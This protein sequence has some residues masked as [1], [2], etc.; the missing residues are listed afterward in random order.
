[1]TVVFLFQ[2]S[3][4]I[5]A[6]RSALFNRTCCLD[7]LVLTAYKHMLKRKCLHVLLDWAISLHDLL[8]RGCFA[9]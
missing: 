2:S 8:N 6:C 5:K 9:L 7:F 3:V 4:P 1:M